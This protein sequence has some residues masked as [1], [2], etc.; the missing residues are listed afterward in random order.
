MFSF[1]MCLIGLSVNAQAAE[2]SSDGDYSQGSAYAEFNTLVAANTMHLNGEYRVLPWLA[3][4]G[5][6][7][8]GKINMLI[9]TGTQVGGRLQLHAMTGK[10]KGHF[11]FATGLGFYNYT[12]T[13][14]ITGTEESDSSFVI[15]PNYFLGYR[16][17]NPE[18]GF[19]FRVGLGSTIGLLPGISSSFGWS[20]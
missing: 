18:G 8:F 1:L 20:F 4:S 11:E 6:L 17:Q 5:G 7:G 3:A 12:F 13:E 10:N 16:L 19:L 15:T 2:F 9:I 14:Q